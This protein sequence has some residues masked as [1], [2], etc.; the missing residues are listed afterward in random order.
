[1]APWMGVLVIGS[2]GYTHCARS[3]SAKLP[4]PHGGLTLDNNDLEF[5]IP[6]LFR[7][8]FCNKMLP[9]FGAVLHHAVDQEI[10]L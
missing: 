6:S 7:S 2:P 9:H 3:P 4:L 10:K 5:M 8:G 1:M